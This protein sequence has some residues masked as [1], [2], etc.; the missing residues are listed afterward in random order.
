MRLDKFRY[1]LTEHVE[2]FMFT[3]DN[4][5]LLIHPDIRNNELIERL[6]LI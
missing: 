2:K 5:K 6:K 3:Y 1:S 4:F